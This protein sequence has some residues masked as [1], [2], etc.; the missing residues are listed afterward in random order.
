MSPWLE[1]VEL[2]VQHV[3]DAGERV[4]VDTMR[5]SESPLD[6]AECETSGDPGIS[7]NV[8]AVVIIDELMTKRLAKGDPDYGRKENTDAGE[9]AAAVTT[10][11]ATRSCTAC[12]R[13]FPFHPR[14]F[15]KI[16]KATM[17]SVWACPD[18]SDS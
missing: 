10:I 3:R 17:G 4:P 8:S 11:N 18:F 2:T 15:F 6:S 1:T 9:Y 12:R 16:R 7:V 5:M 13:F 14:S